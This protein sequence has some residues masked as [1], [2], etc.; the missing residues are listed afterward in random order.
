MKKLFQATLLVISCI[1]LFGANEWLYYKHFPWVYDHQSKEWIYLSGSADGKIYVYRASTN[2]WAEFSTLSDFT[3]NKW[4]EQYEEWVKK[5]EPYGG[6]ETL[7]LIKGAKDYDKTELTLWNTKIKDLTPLSGLTSLEKLILSGNYISDISPLS[8]LTN[9]KFLGITGTGRDDPDREGIEL[10]NYSPIQ[11]LTKLETLV[12][13]HNNISD[14][15]PLSNLSNLE[16]L[17]F[18]VGNVSD[19]SPLTGL[20]KLTSLNLI[21]NSVTDISA[22]MNLIQLENLY[23]ADATTSVNQWGSGNNISDYQK[24]ML[25]SALPNTSISW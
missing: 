2:E 12:I 18:Q 14:I 10:T 19:L 17:S 5:P 3:N 1:P 21:N 7:E 24:T 23:L 25:E 11:N 22:L 15:S 8:D 16:F 9:L 4:Y 20:T 6:I 13:N